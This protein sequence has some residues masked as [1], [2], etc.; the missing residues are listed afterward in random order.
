MAL[1]SETISRV[2]AANAANLLRY[3]ARR[4]LQTDVAVDLVAET[5]AQA[6]ESR[7]R[8][9]GDDDR[10][11]MAW[12]FG[13][14][15]HQLN[16]YY[17]SGAVQRRAMARLGVELRTLTAADHEELEEIVSLHSARPAL[18]DA[19]AALSEE[20]RRA[21]ELRVVQERSYAELAA[22]LGITE[23]AA[24]ARVSRALRSLAAAIERLEG[25]GDYA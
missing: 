16:D 3:F 18:A 23:E 9:R 14:A 13:I 6:F 17:R 10:E 20:Q 5:F 12:I 25:T 11:V 22:R 19:L 1:D 24:R 4:T 2:Y 8:F 15:R 7:A 21:L